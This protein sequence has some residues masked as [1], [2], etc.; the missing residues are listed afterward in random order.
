KDLVSDSRIEINNLYEK[1]I[2]FQF[3]LQIYVEE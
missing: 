2:L 3:N 1:H